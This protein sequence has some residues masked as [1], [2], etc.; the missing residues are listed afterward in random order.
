MRLFAVFVAVCALSQTAAAQTSD[1]KSIPDARLR[2]GC[3]DRAA[4]PVAAAEKALPAAAPAQKS[5]ATKPPGVKPSKVDNS[6]YVD[7][8]GAEDALM[9]ARLKNIC[10]G[11]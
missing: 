6:K 11:C 7:S 10:R 9:N 8:I 3:Y 4:P 2:L 5:A 1:C